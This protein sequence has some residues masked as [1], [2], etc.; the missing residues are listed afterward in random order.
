MLADSNRALL[1]V[2]IAHTEL[3]REDLLKLSQAVSAGPRTLE[4]IGYRLLPD[5]KSTSRAGGKG[6]VRPASHSGG[7]CRVP[8]CSVD[9]YGVA[10]LSHLVDCCPRLREMEYG[11]CA[12]APCLALL[13]APRTGISPPVSSLP[14]QAQRQQCGG[15]W[16]CGTGRMRQAP[17][18]ELLGASPAVFLR[19]AHLACPSPVDG[20]M[21]PCVCVCV[22][23]WDG[24]RRSLSSSPV[25]RLDR[26]RLTQRG[27]RALVDALAHNSTLGHIRQA[28]AG[29]K[30]V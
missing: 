30:S 11:H 29:A 2:R 25:C 24:R 14:R 22:G 19:M 16:R 7:V 27:T 26:C 1:A 12:L 9:D 13:G 4:R 28:G 8:G 17:P 6:L 5:G 15:G 21:H 18:D 20:M 10:S 3:S 23:G